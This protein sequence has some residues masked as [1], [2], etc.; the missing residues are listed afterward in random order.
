V[1]AV[2]PL[3]GCHPEAPLSPGAAT[4]K[5]EIKSCLDNI[6]VTL[7]EPVARKDVAEIHAVLE[8]VESPAVKLCRLCPFEIWVT[9]ASGKTLAS[10]PPKGGGKTKDYSL[11]RTSKGKE[12]MANAIS[13]AKK[14]GSIN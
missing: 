9:E 10:Y 8:K 5:Q 6:A 2:I 13:R 3:F 7:R 1:I 12:F 11:M 14:T 4:F